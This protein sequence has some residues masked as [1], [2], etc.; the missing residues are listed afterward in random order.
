MNI[1]LDTHILLWWAANDRRLS[2]EAR[3]RIADPEN[4][5]VVSAATFWEL[6]IKQHLRRIDI[7]LHELQAAVAE[8]GFVEQ[9]VEVAH[10]LRLKA[11][12]DL[13]RDPFDRL[14]IAQAIDTGARLLTRDDQILAY[15][16]TDGFAPLKA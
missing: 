5:I 12:P 16:G 4:D 15:A 9:P 1:L 8:D 10:T 7:E 11:L 2:S 6:A 3:A 14:L 13:H